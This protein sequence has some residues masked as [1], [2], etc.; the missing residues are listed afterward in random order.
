MSPFVEVHSETLTVCICDWRGKKALEGD[1][2]HDEF[3]AQHVAAQYAQAP[4]PSYQSASGFAAA[5]PAQRRLMNAPVANF[6][7]GDRSYS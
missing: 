5:L 1:G 4:R 3:R 2:G 6:G 7:A